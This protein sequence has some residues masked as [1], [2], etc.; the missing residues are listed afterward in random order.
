MKIYRT[1]LKLVPVAILTVVLPRVSSFVRSLSAADASLDTHDITAF[2]FAAVL[3]LGTLAAAYFSD[4]TPAPEYDEEPTN[5]RERK[6]REREAVYYTTMWQAAPYARRAVYL[7]AFL[8]GMF[9]L[10]EAMTAAFDVG[11]FD[12]SDATQLAVST[13]ALQLPH[14]LELGTLLV[15]GVAVFAFGLSP[16]FLAIGLG[17][18]ISMVD[19]IPVDYERPQQSK[20]IDWVR[21]IMGNLGFREYRYEESSASSPNSPNSPNSRLVA[22]PQARAIAKMLDEYHAEHSAVPA[23]NQLLAMLQDKYKDRAPARSTVSTVRNAWI[24][25]RGL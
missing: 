9:N 12:L 13:G 14:I 8:D 10:A 17:K 15:F 6:R 25:H 24:A 11:K 7:F 16:T 4:E 2:F 21:T 23:F 18:L 19:R 5:P 1:I 22:S 3:G 20:E